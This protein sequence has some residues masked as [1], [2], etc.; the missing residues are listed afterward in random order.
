MQDVIATMVEYF[1]DFSSE[2]IILS[3][4][5]KGCAGDAYMELGDTEN[6]MDSYENAI[7]NSANL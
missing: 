1:D 3:S 4:L 5:A 6:A 7:E 2:D